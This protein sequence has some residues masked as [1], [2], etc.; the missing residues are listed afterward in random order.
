[1]GKDRSTV[2]NYLRLLKLPEELILALREG[3]ISMGHA[4]AILGVEEAEDQIALFRRIE[5]ENLSVR[6]TEEVVKQSK[7]GSESGKPKK[8]SVPTVFEI[9]DA[10]KFKVDRLNKTLNTKIQVKAKG[11]K[12]EIII[13]FSQYHDLERILSHLSDHE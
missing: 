9:D 3:K 10:L 8:S 13:P 1:M 4:K 7:S 11:D 2:S 5:N 6:G 12:G